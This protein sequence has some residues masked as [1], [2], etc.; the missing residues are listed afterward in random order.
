MPNTSDLS[1]PEMHL[2]V[3][4]TCIPVSCTDG[5]GVARQTY[6]ALG[7]KTH[8]DGGADADF[9]LQIQIT[10]MHLDKRLG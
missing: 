8:G 6:D 4:S 2:G 3:T 1:I 7:R 9:A 5:F 10:A